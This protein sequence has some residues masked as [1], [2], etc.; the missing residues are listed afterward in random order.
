MV[1]YERAGVDF[2]FWKRCRHEN[3]VYFLSGAKA[4][5]AFT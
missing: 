4:K 3:A 2:M 5:M 1:V